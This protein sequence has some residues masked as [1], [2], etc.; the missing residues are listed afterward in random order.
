MRGCARDACGRQNVWWSGGVDAAIAEAP[1]KAQQGQ[2]P[3]G[4][5]APNSFAGGHAQDRQRVRPR[6]GQQRRRP[7]IE[8]S[9]REVDELLD[10][11]VL[12]D[13]AAHGGQ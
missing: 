6:L 1:M 8:P 3:G 12:A 13:S 4:D 5:V 11:R 7:G 2:E 9:H 10:E